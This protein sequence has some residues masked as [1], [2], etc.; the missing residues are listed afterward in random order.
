VIRLDLRN[1]SKKERKRSHNPRVWG[2]LPP[3]SSNFALTTVHFF[4]RRPPS[5]LS[6]RVMKRHSDH[7]LRTMGS[8]H[9]LT[10]KLSTTKLGFL[11][12]FYFPTP[13]PL[14]SF[15]LIL[16]THWSSPTARAHTITEF[17]VPRKIWEFCLF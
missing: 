12:F 17:F 9:L 14:L 3:Q 6:D 11:V 8:F 4:L 10:D 5:M 2:R 7:T 15:F 13:R 1:P 16:V